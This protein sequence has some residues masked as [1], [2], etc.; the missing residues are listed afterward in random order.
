M[1]ATI[2]ID[3]FRSID[4]AVLHVK[5]GLNVL[6]GPNGSGK[7]NTLHALK[8][9]SNMVTNGAALA[10]GKAG[11][12]ARNFRRGE[13]SIQFIVV[14]DYEITLYKGRQTPFHLVWTVELSLSSTDNLTFIRDES[15]KVAAWI[16]DEMEDVLVV[17][18]SRRPSGIKTKFW[19][20]DSSLLTK[21]IIESQWASSASNKLTMFDSL[22]KHVSSLL[23]DVRKMPQD[24]SILETFAP[25]HHAVRKLYRDMSALDEYNIQPDVAKQ[26]TDPL[27]VVRM[28]NDGA[29][30]SEV[31][32]T[33]E[34]QQFRRFFDRWGYLGGGAYFGGGPF[35]DYHMLNSMIKRNPLID[36][37]DH[38]RAAVVTID[39]IGTDIDPSTGRRY[40]VFRSGDNTF[41]PEEVSDGTIKW[42]CLLA[43]LYVPRS[44]VI[45]LEEP[46][47]FMHPWMQ[48]RFV[49]LIRDQAKKHEMSV[50]LSTHSVT[51]LN[52]LRL[53]ELLLVRQGDDGTVIELATEDSEI[54]RVLEETNF[55]LGDVWVSGGIGGVVGG[56]Q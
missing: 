45:L 17:G 56:V 40:T 27:P 51:V 50:V 48:Q 33:L 44:R 49:G 34:T 52:S 53:E 6:V 55:G 16:N 35:F 54:E 9:M 32:H 41:R 10:M 28:G 31:L 37:S 24:A 18:V 21:K 42:L 38:L 13:E 26:A 15:L 22:K 25:L 12:P 3:G 29:A 20:A 2:R 1:D 5:P 46:E 8:F 47:N 14:T 36:I 7:T 30:I 43:A 19:I 4:S 11:G 39:S 23:P